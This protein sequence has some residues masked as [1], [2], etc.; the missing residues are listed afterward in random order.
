MLLIITS[1][2]DELHKN[3]NIDDLEPSPLKKAVL[4][5]FSRFCAVTHIL[6]VNCAEMAGDKPR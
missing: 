5:I 3:V 4:V 6:R 1:T 2:S